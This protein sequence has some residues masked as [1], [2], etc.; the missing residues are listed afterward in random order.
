MSGKVITWH[1]PTLIKKHYEIEEEMETE[2]QVYSIVTR[3]GKIGWAVV[4]RP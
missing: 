3:A 4:T 2:E 1:A